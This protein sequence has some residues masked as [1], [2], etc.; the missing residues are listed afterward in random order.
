MFF[1]ANGKCF[2]TRKNIFGGGE[3]FSITHTVSVEN[4]RNKIFYFFKH[5]ISFIIKK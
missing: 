1:L 2:L 5:I 4:R 3:E